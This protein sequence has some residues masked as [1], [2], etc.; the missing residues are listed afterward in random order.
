MKKNFLLIP[1][2]IIFA[3]LPCALFAVGET[4]T[5]QSV[6]YLATAGNRNATLDADAAFFN[7]AGIAFIDEGAVLCMLG[8]QMILQTKKITDAASAD[9]K[10]YEGDVTSYVFPTAAAAIRAGRIGYFFHFGPYGGAGTGDFKDGTPGSAGMSIKMQPLIIGCSLGAAYRLTDSI[11]LAAGAKYFYADKK[12]ELS[13]NSGTFSSEATGSGFGLVAGIDIKPDEKLNI[14]LQYMWNSKL[15]VTNET[16]K[17]GAGLPALAGEAYFPDGGKTRA[18]LP[19]LATLGIS[20]AVIPELTIELNCLLYFEWLNNL[21][22]VEPDPLGTSKDAAG[23][24]ISDHYG[25]GFEAGI[26]IE[27]A[28]IPGRLTINTGWMYGRNGQKQAVIDE[29]SYYQD[30]HQLGIGGTAEITDQ[31]GI[32]AGYMISI[33]LPGKKSWDGNQE[34]NDEP[35]HFIGLGLKGKFSI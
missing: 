13:D 1:A 35:A 26:G 14:S 31:I 30:Y 18:Q 15:E 5:T 21:G 27:Y 19:M 25:P 16:K 34:Y 22:K 9:E 2:V 29:F 6:L 32:M 7:P 23:D 4:A 28:A 12:V 3:A 33:M 8:N 10:E 24:D 11:G 17:E 20:Y